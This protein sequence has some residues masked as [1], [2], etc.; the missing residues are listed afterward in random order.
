M[1]VEAS[2]PQ[3]IEWVITIHF[4]K[5]SSGPELEIP[6]VANSC[7][8]YIQSRSSCHPYLTDNKTEQGGVQEHSLLPDM[9]WT[10]DIW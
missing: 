4:L 5:H 2:I 1:L 7:D 3:D 9:V 10:Q 8:H 6:M